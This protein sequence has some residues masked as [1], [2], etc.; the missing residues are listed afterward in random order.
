MVTGARPV[1][2]TSETS[3]LLLGVVGHDVV[4]SEFTELVD[5]FESGDSCTIGVIVGVVGWSFWLVAE[6]TA[7]CMVFGVFWW[8]FCG[9]WNLDAFLIDKR[10]N[11]IMHPRMSAL[12]QSDAPPV[13]Q[14]LLTTHCQSSFPNDCCQ[15][16]R[17][18]KTSST[19]LFFSTTC[20][21]ACCWAKK[22]R[23]KWTSIAC[24]SA[25]TRHTKVR[26]TAVPDDPHWI[27][28]RFA[29]ATLDGALHLATGGSVYVCLCTGHLG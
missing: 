15:I 19:R 29:Y 7:F 1:F 6:P 14:G 24:K 28:D 27:V 23:S 11:A 9:W 2:D 17:C 8:F 13:Y 20:A 26:I 10:G 18:L 16:L 12:V 25:A 5:A 21:R 3:P 22:V 4:L